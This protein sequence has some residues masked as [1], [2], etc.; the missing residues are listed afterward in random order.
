[1][2]HLLPPNLLR[3]FAPRPPIP[4]IKPIGRDPDIPLN[5]KLDGIAGIFDEL[6]DQAAL[7]EA[8]EEER[9]AD[10][11]AA[12]AS[13]SSSKQRKGVKKEEPDDTTKPPKGGMQVDG[14]RAGGEDE[15]KENAK[16]QGE[17]EE[18]E[19]VADSKPDE[20]KTKNEESS[21]FTYTAAEKYRQ[22]QIEKKRKRE[23]DLKRASEN[24]EFERV[25]EDLRSSMYMGYS[26]LL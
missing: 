10:A 3:L 6:R 14:I 16:E 12:S 18:G 21:G 17:M 9:K 19:D 4:Y 8:E 2:T 25:L 23:E 5:K 22:K 13:A 24:C 20:E 15:D 1:M 7:K 26:G 11:E